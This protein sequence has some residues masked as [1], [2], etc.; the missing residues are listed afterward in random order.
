MREEP[1]FKGDCFA[2]QFD[3]DLLCAHGCFLLLQ[4]AEPRTAKR[5]DSV[6]VRGLEALLSVVPKDSDARASRGALAAQAEATNQSLIA[7]MVV[8]V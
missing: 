7:L 5:I 1:R 8:A 6:R 3:G 4:G 2:A